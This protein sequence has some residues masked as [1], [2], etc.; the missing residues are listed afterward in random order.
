[1]RFLKL[2]S[3]E[4]TVDI[5]GSQRMGE[6]SPGR[7]DDPQVGVNESPPPLPGSRRYGV[8]SEHRIDRWHPA[9]GRRATNALQQVVIDPGLLS[10]PP[11]ADH[12]SREL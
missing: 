4:Q 10:L 11:L 12:P 1:M 2:S 5:L 3:A 9:D 7:A 8:A 6:E